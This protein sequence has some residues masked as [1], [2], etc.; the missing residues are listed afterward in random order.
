M[1]E[2]FSVLKHSEGW[3]IMKTWP[4]IWISTM[5]WS[6]YFTKSALRSLLTL[7]QEPHLT[8][9]APVTQGRLL[10]PCSPSRTLGRTYGSLTS[11]PA[12][13]S[14]WPA[15]GPTLM[16]RPGARRC[17]SRGQPLSSRDSLRSSLDSMVSS[18][19]KLSFPCQMWAMFRIQWPGEEHYPVQLWWQGDAGAGWLYRFS[20]WLSQDS[21]H[22]AS[23]HTR[24]G[25]GPGPRPGL[26][27][28]DA[29]GGL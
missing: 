24:G 15:P 8:L 6:I 19:H 27:H 12:L 11:S 17:L 10:S 23:R 13:T 22:L 20:A 29:G 4:K 3:T 5:I 26:G 18:K 1:L 25:P 14:A 9:A 16:A 2:T 28:P 7:P 21:V